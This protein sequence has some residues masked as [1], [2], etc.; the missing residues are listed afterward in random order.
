MGPFVSRWPRHR[1]D[2]LG[3]RWL[4]HHWVHV[5]SARIRHGL[6]FKIS[7]HEV[8]MKCHGKKGRFPHWDEMRLD[9]SIHPSL[10][11]KHE[12]FHV[13]LEFMKVLLVYPADQQM[14]GSKNISLLGAW[15]GSR[16]VFQVWAV[17]FQRRNADGTSE[18][19][20]ESK[21]PNIHED[22][23]SI[24]SHLKKYIPR[25]EWQYFLI[26]LAWSIL[27]FCLI[28][29]TFLRLQAWYV[30]GTWEE[31]GYLACLEKRFWF[32]VPDNR[33]HRRH[34]TFTSLF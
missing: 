5:Q 34:S 17:A 21:V 3:R 18:M 8:T 19:R 1:G 26:L 7:K 25:P 29:W 16:F 30:E 4:V 24:W 12:P 22:L 11:C 31:A 32:D 20:L 28:C 27:S 9:F 2:R 23:E 15:D 10:W 33:C 13:A 6:V 14:V